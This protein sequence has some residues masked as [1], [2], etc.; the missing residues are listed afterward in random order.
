MR[1]GES[2]VTM[3][4]KSTYMESHIEEETLKFWVGSRPDFE[5]QKLQNPAVKKNIS[6]ILEISKEGRGELQRSEAAKEEDEIDGELS[7]E[8]RRKIMLIEKF[9]EVFSGRKVKLQVAGKIKELANRKNIDISNLPAKNENV[10]NRSGWG[11]EYDYRK[12]YYEKETMTF[13]AK[14]MVKTSDGRNIE[15]KID[16]DMKREYTSYES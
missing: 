1:I 16:L 3:A 7:S 10:Q 12:Q 2:S 13:S 11:L 4:S 6:D 15:F 5:A 14:G 9:I 8:D